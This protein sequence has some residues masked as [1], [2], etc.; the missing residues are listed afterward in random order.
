MFLISWFITGLLIAL[1]RIGSKM[2]SL[3][4]VSAMFVTSLLMLLTSWLYILFSN[5]TL[6]LPKT[7]TDY[8]ASIF[9]GCTLVI[10]GVLIVR[11]FQKWFSVSTFVPY[12]T[13]VGM[14]IIL[15]YWFF[16]GEV[17]TVKQIIGFVLS[18]VA[19]WLLQ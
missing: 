19:I 9:M 1:Y 5:H 13:I 12:Y 10:S 15:G 7:P 11:G 2:T 4:P 6:L 3:D 8:V 14:I 18:L 16:I 17:L